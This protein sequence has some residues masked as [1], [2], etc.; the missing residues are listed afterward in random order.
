M[1]GRRI[2]LVFTLLAAIVMTVV[3][4]A[5]GV[6][7]AQEAPVPTLTSATASAGGGED[8]SGSGCAARVSVQIQFDSALLLTTRSTA[9]GRYRAHL[10]IPVSAVPGSHRI[11]VVCAGTKGQVT[12]ATT[13]SV[14][15]PRTG[16]D[17]R[18][19]ALT[20]MLLLLIGGTLAGVRRRVL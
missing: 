20:A 6:A 1:S 11:T 14:G 4:P 19:L 16:S 13:V 8:I 9:T 2:G 10:L 18:P 3:G 5:V 7:H 12:S 17:P 15:L